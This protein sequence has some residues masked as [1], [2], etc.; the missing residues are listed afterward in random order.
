MGLT[1]WKRLK[2]VNEEALDL[3]EKIFQFE[4]KRIKMEQILKHPFVNLINSKKDEQIKE[5]KQTEANIE[6]TVSD[7]SISQEVQTQN[8]P[9]NKNKNNNN[10]TA[11]APPGQ[12]TQSVAEIKDIRNHTFKTAKAQSF[13]DRLKADSLQIEQL[14]VIME[15]VEKMHSPLN[16]QPKNTN[17]NC[18]ELKFEI[19]AI[20]RYLEKRMAVTTQESE[21]QQQQKHKVERVKMTADESLQNN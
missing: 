17:D 16:K 2:L 15:D 18:A 20:Y 8:I 21:Q 4:S 19:E 10:E 6:D 5:V 3:L 11:V 13:A 1:H 9:N 12:T 14:K 7:K